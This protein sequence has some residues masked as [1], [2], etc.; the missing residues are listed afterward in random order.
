LDW[1][2]AIAAGHLREAATADR[3]AAHAQ[4]IY[5]A[6]SHEQSPISAEE[7]ATFLTIQGWQAYAHGRNNEA[8]AKL[9]AAAE[10]QD[11]VGQAEVDIPAR[12]MYA[13]MLYSLGRPEDALIQFKSDLRLSP[14]R[15]N[16]LVGAARSALKAGNEEA[17]SYSMQLLK[18]T[19]GGRYSSRPEISEARRLSGGSVK[20]SAHGPS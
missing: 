3:V 2:Q 13:D 1:A 8:L 16:G 10:E 18:I 14:N 5:E 11:R 7:H 12:E 17:R 19:N 15:F 4:S 9:S 6:V 20:T